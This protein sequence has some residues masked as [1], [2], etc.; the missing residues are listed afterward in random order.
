MVV[1]DLL[2]IFR[3]YVYF[4]HSSWGS[5]TFRE[6][7]VLIDAHIIQSMSMVLSV[8]FFPSFDSVVVQMYGFFLFFP[9][10]YVA[11]MTVMEKLFLHVN[12]NLLKLSLI[13]TNTF[14]S[15]IPSENLLNQF[16][17]I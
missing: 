16:G 15:S 8:L 11:R 4:W 5:Q 9:L 17:S 13:H 3:D 2:H 12:L 10:F 1:D 14:P 7:G 6:V